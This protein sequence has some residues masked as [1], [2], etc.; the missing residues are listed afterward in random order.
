MKRFCIV[1][2]YL[3][4][5]E[6]LIDDVDDPR[7]ILRGVRRNQEMMDNVFVR[8]S[9][10]FSLDLPD[11]TLCVTNRTN[12]SRYLCPVRIIIVPPFCYFDIRNKIY[13]KQLF[14]VY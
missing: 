13:S 7:S 5:I 11:Y 12:I 4:V 10:R 14:A 1:F 2:F 9:F 8:R 6:K 3:N